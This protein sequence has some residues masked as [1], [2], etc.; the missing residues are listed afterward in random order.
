MFF[1]EVTVTQAPPIIMCVT[2]ELHGDVK[3]A[4]QGGAPLL[5]MNLRLYYPRSQ[6]FLDK[7]DK[8]SWESDHIIRSAEDK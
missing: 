5:Q 6:T 8:N 4:S 2:V 3:Y 7:R 1:R